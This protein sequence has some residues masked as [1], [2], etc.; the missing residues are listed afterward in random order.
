M[1]RKGLVAR[2]DSS[3]THVY[4]AKVSRKDIE[5]LVVTD[6]IDRLFNGSATRLVSAALA[7][8]RASDHDLEDI[9]ALLENHSADEGDDGHEP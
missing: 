7:T 4:R 1:L 3:K 8:R 6:L 5:G 2:D 9:A